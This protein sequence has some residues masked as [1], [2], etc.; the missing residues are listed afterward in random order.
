MQVQ[1]RDT[2]L[3]FDVEGPALVPDGVAMRTRPTM[4]LLHGGPG[5]YDHSYFKPWFAA[6]TDVAQVVYLDLPD[7]GRSARG[8]A[9]SWS[10]ERCADDVAAFCSTVGLVRPVVLGHSMGG[11]VAILLG[12]RH[13][14]V[15]GALILQSTMARFHLDRLTE[16]F[17]RQGGD[18]IAAL[19]R[20][21]YS[22]QREVTDAEWARVYAAF[23]PR[24][25]DAATL[26]RRIR[27]PAVA[28]RGM[29]LMRRLDLRD[30]LPRITCPTLI[31][32]GEL[33]PVTPLEAAQEI[34]A[35]LAPGVGQLHVLSGA[36]HFP[37]LDDAT[38]CFAAIRGFLR[39]VSPRG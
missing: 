26:A 4:L 14:A 33:D 35:G 21:D 11:F 28:E 27:N 30:Q 37:W 36:G 18:E 32:V 1:V 9:A 16:G 19:A 2:T 13:P 8:D 3:W 29:D 6:L 24:V 7:H 25:P 5:S 10:F 15:A 39:E 34:V 22:G 23:G 17:R 31:G 12:A 38:A 20:L